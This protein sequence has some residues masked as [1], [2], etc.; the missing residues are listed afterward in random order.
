MQLPNFH[1]VHFSSA[2]SSL[3]PSHAQKTSATTDW[4][5]A[6][7][8]KVIFYRPSSPPTLTNPRIQEDAQLNFN[9]ISAAPRDSFFLSSFDL[10]CLLRHALS[11]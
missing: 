6:V 2:L 8:N 11:A 5:F 3:V 7:L 1:R 4:G 10:V 9:P